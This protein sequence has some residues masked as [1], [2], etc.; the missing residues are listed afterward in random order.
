M[1]I[2]GNCCDNAMQQLFFENMKCEI[3]YKNCTI[4]EELKKTNLMVVWIIT[5]IN[6]SN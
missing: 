1:L 6:V 2:K 4:I 5:I 3:V